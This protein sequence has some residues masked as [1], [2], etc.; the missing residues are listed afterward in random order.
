MLIINLFVC[1]FLYFYY[2]C[3]PNQINVIKSKL[4]A[5][6]LK[7]QMSQ[8]EIADILGMTQ[9]TYSRKEKGITNITMQ[10]WTRLA[11][12]FGVEKDEIYQAN[13]SPKEIFKALENLNIPPE[14]LDKINFLQKENFEL[15]QKL[16]ILEK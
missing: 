16:R 9:S 14:L 5:L 15:Q 11:K 7:K 4:K 6:R 10:E 3:L 1:K 2:Y 12:V 8:E 13:I